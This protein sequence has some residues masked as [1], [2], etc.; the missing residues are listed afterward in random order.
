MKQRT[1]ADL[2][3]AL[4]RYK[5]CISR[6]HKTLDLM[7]P[8]GFSRLDE[9][10]EDAAAYTQAISDLTPTPTRVLDVGSGVGLPAVVVAVTFPDLP[11]QLVE[12]RARRATFLRIA[13]SET[14]ATNAEVVEADVA[15]LEGPPVDLV[16]AQAVGSLTALYEM[17][18]HRHAEEVVILSRKG[19]NWP[20]EV[21]ELA[22]ATGKTPVVVVSRPLQHHGTLVAVRIQGGAACQSSAS[23]TKKGA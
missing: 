11:L 23:S 12:R 21:Q 16:T 4:D 5:D 2:K 18:R 20:D 13:L 3:S 19:P 6:Y 22:T 8:Q 1:A 10:L 7:S 15:R 9:H 17:T 14:Q